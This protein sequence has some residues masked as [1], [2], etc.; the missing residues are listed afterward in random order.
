[1][2]S[3]NFEGDPS[4]LWETHAFSTGHRARQMVLNCSV[5]ERMTAA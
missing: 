3:L 2:D 4:Q 1:M 5:L